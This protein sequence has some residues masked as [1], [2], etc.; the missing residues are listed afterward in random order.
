MHVVVVVMMVTFHA[1]VGRPADAS[2]EG[3]YYH[4]CTDGFNEFVDSQEP[5][6]LAL[7]G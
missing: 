7:G 6:A 3:M 2:R 5:N 4:L 1:D